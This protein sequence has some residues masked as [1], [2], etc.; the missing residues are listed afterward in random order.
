MTIHETLALVKDLGELRSFSRFNLCCRCHGSLRR[1][2]FS[3][4]L[5]AARDLEKKN[6]VYSGCCMRQGL[7]N[8]A[9]GFHDGSRVHSAVLAKFQLRPFVSWC[10]C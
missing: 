7:W 3:E 1:R 4:F 2:D 8:Y 5:P 9:I 10:L 6:F